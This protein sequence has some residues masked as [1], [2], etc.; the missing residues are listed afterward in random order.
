[1][2]SVIQ[3]MPITIII[4]KNKLKLKIMQRFNKKSYRNK[5]GFTK[6]NIIYFCHTSAITGSILF[7]YFH[8]SIQRIDIKQKQ[9]NNKKTKKN[10]V[11]RV[12]TRRK[13]GWSI[14]TRRK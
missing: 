9:I 11:D 12:C 8:Q 3:G 14:C 1:M 10:M 4:F 2:I 6:C 13:N 5:F 7:I